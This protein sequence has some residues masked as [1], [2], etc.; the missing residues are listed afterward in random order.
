LFTSSG[1]TLFE[2]M[3]S[4]PEY[5]TEAELV[6]LM[7]K[8]GIGTDGSISRHIEKI[9]TCKYVEVSSNFCV[10]LFT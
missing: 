6:T 4:P 7:E 5:L 3:T 10:L 1:V 8:H 2:G 9:N